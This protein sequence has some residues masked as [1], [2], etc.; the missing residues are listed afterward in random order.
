LLVET[1]VRARALLAATALALAPLVATVPSAQAA[2]RATATTPA[3]QPLHGTRIALGAIGS[4]YTNAF[5]EAPNG[6]VFFSRGAVVYVV[7]GS[8]APV[9]ALHAGATVLALG[10]N[11]SDLFVE[12]GLRVTEY[13]RATG[14]PVRHWTL[15]SLSAPVISAAWTP[16]AE[17]SG[18]GPT[19]PPTAAASSTRRSTAC[20]RRARPCTWSTR[21][22]SPA[23]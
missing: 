22:R 6:A 4:L 8:R 18:R 11:D 16:S 20:T 5:A 14:S 2:A 1:E 19:G 10:A 15:T 9:I 13:S 21:T 3:T 23:T 7:E 12:T 17:P